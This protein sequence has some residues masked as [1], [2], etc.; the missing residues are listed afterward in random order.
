MIDLEACRRRREE[1]RAA[2][3]RAADALERAAATGG[4]EAIGEARAMLHTARGE[5]DIAEAALRDADAIG[6]VRTLRA[7]PVSD[8]A[9]LGMDAPQIGKYSLLRAL[10]AQA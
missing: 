6:Q 5:F 8:P 10:D 3:E 4:D 2:L 9:L 1:A 7:H